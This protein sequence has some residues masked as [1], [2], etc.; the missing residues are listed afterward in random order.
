MRP[1][2]PEREIGAGIVRY[3]DGGHAREG[4]HLV[5]LNGREVTVL[6]DGRTTAR[7]RSQAITAALQ[8]APDPLADLVGTLILAGVSN[9]AVDGIPIVGE[10]TDRLLASMRLEVSQHDSGVLVRVLE[11]G[12]V[13]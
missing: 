10:S 13:S 2:G 5:A 9:L 12:G 4:G 1:L 3:L 6:P 7:Q 8:A 11:T